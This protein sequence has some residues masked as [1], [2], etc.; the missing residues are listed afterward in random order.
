MATIINGEV[1]TARCKVTWHGFTL[2]KGHLFGTTVDGLR[3]VSACRVDRFGDLIVYLQ[4]NDDPERWTRDYF[5]QNSALGVEL[6]AA[7][8]RR[9]ADGVCA[10]YISFSFAILSL[11]VTRSFLS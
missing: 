8:R 3:F 6:I 10:V 2:Q 7:V 9:N 1:R 11:L 5:S 4:N